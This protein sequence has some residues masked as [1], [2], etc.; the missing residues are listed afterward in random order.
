[1][2]VV[3][4]YVCKVEYRAT[5]WLNPVHVM[6]VLISSVTCYRSVN[7]TPW[8]I[9]V[10]PWLITVIPWL[11]TVIPRLITVIRGSLP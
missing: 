10:I 11:I 3:A 9:A 1:M 2:T 7:M 5:P 4:M 8:L 6:C